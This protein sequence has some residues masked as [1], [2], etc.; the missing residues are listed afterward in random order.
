M[1]NPAVT[2]ALDESNMNNTISDLKPEDNDEL[3][4]ESVDWNS[5]TLDELEEYGL[6][7]T[8]KQV[9]GEKY[10]SMI[11]LLIEIAL[12]SYIVIM[13]TKNSYAYKYLTY[14]HTD[15]AIWIIVDTCIR[16][17]TILLGL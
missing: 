4:L 9:E 5:L 14:H 16:A 3:N 17:M 8:P 6:S 10:E 12:F 13:I 15:L 2:G 7:G 11:H 1:S